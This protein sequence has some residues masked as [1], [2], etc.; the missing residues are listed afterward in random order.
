MNDL[1]IIM[2]TPNKVPKEWAKYHKE[3]LL[4]AVGNTRVITVS[5]EPL[6][7]GTNIIQDDYGLTN[8]YRQML[9]ASKLAETEF[10]AMADDD[11]LYPSDHFKYRP[12]ANKFA[13][14]LNR[15][16]LFS[17]R[18]GKKAYYFHKPRPG[19]GLM[20]APR[21]LVITALENRLR[22]RTEL[23]SRLS[24]ELGIKSYSRGCDICDYDTFYS[25]NPVVSF[26]HRESIDPLNQ[27]M[28]KSPW[29]VRAF[30]LPLWR[31]A[32]DLIEKFV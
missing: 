12:E 1:T 5:N 31:R 20:I 16:H 28:R 10:I 27:R 7:W 22:N 24:G 14:N 23:P 19:N 26:Y 21:Q 4:K 18:S 2:L 29:P 6:D 8:I 30:D 17:W 9:R 15:W 11:T 13:Y 25:H 3:M 32:S